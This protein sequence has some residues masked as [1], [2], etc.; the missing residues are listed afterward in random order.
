[1]DGTVGKI[2]EFPGRTM[3]APTPPV[4]GLW[5][6][7]FRRAYE[8]FIGAFLFSFCFFFFFSFFLFFFFLLLPRK[9]G[10]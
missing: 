6:L 8:S 5:I 1:M 7:Y 10:S 3:L 4:S 9:R 2:K